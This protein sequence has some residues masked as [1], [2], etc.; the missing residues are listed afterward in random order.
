V[1]DVS[2]TEEDK[3]IWTNEQKASTE[4]KVIRQEMNECIRQVI[5][6]LPDSYRSVIVLSELEGFKDNEIA[7]VIGL[8]LEATKIRIHRARARL[9]NELTKTCVFYRDEQNE[10]AC[11][12][13]DSLIKINGVK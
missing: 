11:D 13:K 5:E 9:K 10:F 12:R 7:D 4:Q 8:S 1:E 6:L 2:E 3:N